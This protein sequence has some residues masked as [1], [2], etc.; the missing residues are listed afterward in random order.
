MKQQKQRRIPFT[1]EEDDLLFRY[2]AR[3]A[4]KT[5]QLKGNKMYE[6]FA[7]ENPRHPAQ[8]WRD[9][10]IR[11][12]LPR[13]TSTPTATTTTT[14][15]PNVDIEWAGTNTFEFWHDIKAIEE[16]IPSAP[17]DFHNQHVLP[18][19]TG[20]D[21]NL[22]TWKHVDVLASWIDRKGR[23]QYYFKQ[24]QYFFKLLL[25]GSV[26][27]F[28]PKTFHE[29]CDAKGPTVI[30]IKPA[31][32]NDLIGGYNPIGWISEYNRQ[33]PIKLSNNNGK[34]SRVRN[35]EHAVGWHSDCGPDF[36]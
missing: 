29:L 31:R 23:D 6:A 19:R 9:R 3:V 16:W 14:Q 35:K 11:C 28:T 12:V 33:L 8:S 20:I 17:E 30:L 25:R 7:V 22:I 2:V 27:G 34:I 4:E 24:N 32:S 5:D 1:Q 26:S 13:L 36:G 18:P 21:S 10:A 15:S